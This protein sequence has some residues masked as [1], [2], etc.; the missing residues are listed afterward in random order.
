MSKSSDHIDRTLRTLKKK[1][2]AVHKKRMR[3]WHAW[4]MVG[5]FAGMTAIAGIAANLS[6][7]FEGIFAAR[8]SGAGKS[9]VTI[10]GKYSEFYNFPKRF[11]SEANLSQ[12]K[13]LRVTD[14]QYLSLKKMHNGIVPYAF[15][16]VEYDASVYGATTPQGIKIG[17][18]AFPK[19]NNGHPRWEVMAHE[20]GHNFFGGTS[21]FYYTL[22][23]PGPF[24]Q[25]SLAVLSAFYTYHDIIENSRIY[26]MDGTMFR[27]LRYDFDNGRKYQEKQFNAYGIA[28][29][30]FNEYDVLTSQAL[31]YKMI[32]FGEKYGWQNYTKVTKAF[33]DGIA[34]KFDFHRDGVSGIERSTYVIAVLSAAF[35]K[36]FRAEF[37]ELHFPI[38]DA[39]Y[40]KMYGIIR[41]YINTAEARK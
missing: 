19:L 35:A 9:L 23:V 24:L 5:I 7:S 1:Y 37:A 29:T 21:A 2:V 25:E 40:G 26:Q 3:P 22:A 32:L 27:S 15:A 39:L 31:D 17:D 12:K 33:E 36:D 16:R 13:I 4:F 28:G 14:A 41:E 38:D 10:K 34:E 6:G 8:L 30:P 11:F 20:Q 18:P